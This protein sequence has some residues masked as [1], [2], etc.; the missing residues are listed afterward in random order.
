MS[1]NV[2]HSVYVDLLRSCMDNLH[3]MKTSYDS[4]TSCHSML[5]QSE[6]MNEIYKHCS[7]DTPIYMRRGPDDRWIIQNSFHKRDN[8]YK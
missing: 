6:I 3:K 4:Q 8:E 7:P 2:R 5:K 1:V